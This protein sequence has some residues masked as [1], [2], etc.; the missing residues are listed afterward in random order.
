YWRACLLPY[1]AEL[2]R[3]EGFHVNHKRVSPLSSDWAGR[4]SLMTSFVAVKCDRFT[5][6]INV[7]LGSH[8][9][10]KRVF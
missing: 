6:F 9:V 10:V 4:K 7:L 8:H 3:R 1:L 2:V 5:M